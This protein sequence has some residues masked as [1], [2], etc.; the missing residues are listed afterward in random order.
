MTTDPKAPIWYLDKVDDDGHDVFGPVNLADLRDWAMAAKISPLDRV[1]N[2]GQKS[3]DR[4]PMVPNLHM[5]WL[6]EVS[7]NF[8]YGPNT[9]GTIQEFIA[10]GEIDEDVWVINCTDGS[11]SMIRDLPV[12]NNAPRKSPVAIESGS[13][14]QGN[15]PA[16]N[17][18]P[19]EMQK[20][21]LELE[22]LVLQQKRTIIDWQSRHHALRAKHQAPNGKDA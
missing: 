3:W 20:R 4:A 1:S 21:I 8:L 5:D 10:N 2:D 9:I 13:P 18:S 11:R 6:L 12:F 15:T 22:A 17:L 7:E 19:I 16:R 14:R